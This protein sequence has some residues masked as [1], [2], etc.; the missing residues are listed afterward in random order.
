VFLLLLRVCY[1]YAMTLDTLERWVQCAGAVALVAALAAVFFGLARGLRRQQKSAVRWPAR[2]LRAPLFYAA[3]SVG[4]FGLCYLIWRPLPWRLSAS[5]RAFSL[6]PGSLLYFPGLGL[7]L[8]AR[9]TLGRM[10]FVSSSFEAPLYADH[11]LITTGPFALVRHPMYLGILLA[12][13]GGILIYWTWTFVFVT[14]NFFGLII[15]A[16]REEEALAAAFGPEWESYRCRVPAWLPR[17][18]R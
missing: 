17:L 8:W 2:L 11:H 9:L 13:L 12:G 1:T 3:A 4:Y 6:L 7:L 15:R 10:Y 18:R 16:R 14:G 5:G